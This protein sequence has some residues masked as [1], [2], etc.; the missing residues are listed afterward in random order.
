MEKL[1][2]VNVCSVCG[3]VHGVRKDLDIKT[4]KQDLDSFKL[5]QNKIACAKQAVSPSAIPDGVDESKVKLFIQSAIDSLAN[6]QWLEQDLWNMIIEKYSLPKDK[7]VYLDF[8][9]G[10]FYYLEG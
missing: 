9:D 3:E 6:Y 10:S 7:N 2:Q 1:K 8:N 5:I 4:D